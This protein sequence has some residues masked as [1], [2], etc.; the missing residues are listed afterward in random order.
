MEQLQICSGWTRGDLRQLAPRKKLLKNR[1]SSQHQVFEPS[2]HSLAWRVFHFTPSRAPIPQQFIQSDNRF[3]PSDRMRVAEA[4]R[5]IW[6]NII[7]LNAVNVES[8]GAT[9]PNPSATNAFRPEL[10][11][12]MDAARGKL[13]ARIS[14]PAPRICGAIAA[15]CL[16]RKAS[17][18]RCRQVS[19]RL[20]KRAAWAS[21]SARA[22]ST[23]RT[24]PSA[25]PR[26]RSRIASWRWLWQRRAVLD[27]KW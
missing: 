6:P 16:S 17:K 15:C 27:S 25:S 20:W 24:M 18:A 2:P 3:V 22:I 14:R 10:R 7:S 1:T 26:S 4:G 8:S 13:P 19:R 9:S 5:P 23:L 21:G 12:I 11:L